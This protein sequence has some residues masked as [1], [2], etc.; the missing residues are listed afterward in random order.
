MDLFLIGEI[1]IKTLIMVN[2][3]FFSNGNVDHVAMIALFK[4]ELVYC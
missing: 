2:I 1:M 3:I 4:I